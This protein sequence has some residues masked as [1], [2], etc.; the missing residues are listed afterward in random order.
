[1]R[2]AL[3]LLVADN[4]KLAATKKNLVAVFKK[5]TNDIKYIERE[6]SCLKKGG[7]GKRDPT[8]CPH[9]KKRGYHAPEACYGLVK[10]NTSAPLVGKDCCDG[11]GQ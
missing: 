4:T 3:P 10:K 6:T 9:F 5:L 1:M 7:Q 2:E 8:L 11:V